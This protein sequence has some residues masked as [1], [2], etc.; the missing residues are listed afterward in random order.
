MTPENL[1]TLLQVIK[2]WS[3]EEIGRLIYTGTR[4]VSSCATVESATREAAIALGNLR[5]HSADIAEIE[6][7]ST[8]VT[9][10]LQTALKTQI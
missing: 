3:N 9:E 2:R 4:P 5:A 8:Y 10:C 6:S 7:V 1:D